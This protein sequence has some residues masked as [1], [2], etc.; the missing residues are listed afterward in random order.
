MTKSDAVE[1]GNPTFG[2]IAV[3]KLYKNLEWSH[4]CWIAVLTI[5]LDFDE[6]AGK[7]HTYN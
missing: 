1:C 2:P 3:I 6:K 5:F 4:C 7:Y